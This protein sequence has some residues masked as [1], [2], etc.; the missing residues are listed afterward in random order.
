VAQGDG[1]L[2]HQSQH[3]GDQGYLQLLL[4]VSK[5][6]SFPRLTA[7]TINGKRIVAFVRNQLVHN[8]TL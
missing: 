5:A 2:E 1:G 4:P 8:L 6:L 3:R 7:Q